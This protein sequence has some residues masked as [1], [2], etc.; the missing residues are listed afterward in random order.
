V[1][2]AVEGPAFRRCSPKIVILPVLFRT[3]LKIVILSGAQRS[4]RTCIL[5]ELATL[6][7][8]FN[9]LSGAKDGILSLLLPVLFRT[10]LKIVILSG[11]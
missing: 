3:L 10:L 2:A 8:W 9:N 4:R 5:L 1:S 7:N 6:P 11:A